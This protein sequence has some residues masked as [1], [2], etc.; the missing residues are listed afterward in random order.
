M[1]RQGELDYKDWA[2]RYRKHLLEEVMAFWRSRTIDEAGGFFTFFDRQGN[3]KGED[4]YIW[5]QARQTYIFSVLYSNVQNDPVWLEHARHG[6]DFL[7]KH[8][9]AGNGRWYYRLDREG[10][11][12][13]GD[14]SMATDSF[15]LCALC[16]YAAASGRDEDI[17]LIE[18]TYAAYEK[19]M[20]D[21]DNV[22]FYH[23]V[24][25]PN[26]SHHSLSM[27]C[28][29]TCAVA[30]DILGEA[31]V[32]PLL[33]TNIESVLYHFAKDEQECLFEIVNRDGSTV[34]SEE[35]RVVNPGHALESMWFCMEAGLHAKDRAIV[36]RCMQIADWHIAKGYDR[37]YGGMFSFINPEGEPIPIR[38][39][40]KD[41]GQSWDSK[42]WWVHSECLYITALCYVHSSSPVW[43]KRFLELHEF[44]S[45]HF[46]DREYGEWYMYLNRDGT[47]SN[48]DKGNAYKSAFHVPRA[49]MKI[50]LLF[51]G[52]ATRLSQEAQKMETEKRLSP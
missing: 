1:E 26:Y 20:N 33:Y 23:Y 25:D 13:E 39:K 48:P 15:V 44:A 42:I 12:L 52:E 31:R 22:E 17:K 38:G 16:V 50:Y 40:A 9:Y 32:R 14:R 21:P 29:N 28:V 49:L 34:D 2:E 43:L 35:G 24:F 27:L 5:V 6:R 3:L 4:K 18:E 10:K 36:D 45:E 46:Y 30:R 8:A 37:Q 47:V 51:L 7:V 19:N 11:L 41:A